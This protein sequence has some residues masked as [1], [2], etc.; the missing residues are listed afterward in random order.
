MAGI[1]NKTHIH[2]GFL[3]RGMV[4]NSIFK[5]MVQP[6]QAIGKNLQN[7]F[8]MGKISLHVWMG[9]LLE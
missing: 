3:I 9:L 8:V 1:I 4:I 2:G 7:I 6:F 5:K